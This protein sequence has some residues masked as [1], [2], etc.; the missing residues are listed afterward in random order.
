LPGHVQAYRIKS[1][2]KVDEQKRQDDLL[3]RF[4]EG[5]KDFDVI[6]GTFGLLSTGINIPALDTIIFA[7]DLKSSVLCVQS[8]GRILRLFEGKQYPKIID[9]DDCK[10]GILHNQARLRKKFYKDNEWEIL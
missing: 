6:L 1:Q 8:V 10:S 4:R 3:A 7:G 5:G 2:L 9:I